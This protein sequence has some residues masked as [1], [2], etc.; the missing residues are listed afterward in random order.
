MAFHSTTHCF[1]SPVWLT[2][3]GAAFLAHVLPAM[4]GT[5]T[6]VQVQSLAPHCL[7]N[8]RPPQNNRPAPQ[9]NARFAPAPAAPRR[10]ASVSVRLAATQRP[11]QNSRSVSVES[12]QERE[13]EH[14]QRDSQAPRRD[15]HYRR[16]ERPEDHRARPERHEDRRS[17]RDRHDGDRNG[18]ERD[19]N[20]NRHERDGNRD[21]RDGRRR[22]ESRGDKEP[23]DRERECAAAPRPAVRENERER[24]RDP[25]G[26]QSP[27]PSNAVVGA[28]SGAPR[29]HHS[30]RVRLDVCRR[31]V[32]VDI[33]LGHCASGSRSYLSNKDSY[34]F[35]FVYFR[36][37]Y[38]CF[39]IMSI[40][41]ICCPFFML[42]Y[43]DSWIDLDAASGHHNVAVHSLHPA[44]NS[45]EFGK[46]YASVELRRV[47]ADETAGGKVDEGT[48]QHPPRPPPNPQTSET[49]R[50]SKH[51]LPSESGNLRT[52]YGNFG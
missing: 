15:D 18:H 37:V 44:S 46:Y 38:V 28:A 27:R 25:Q 52:I 21:K 16:A 50:L 3:P 48:E 9:Q 24:R 29:Y 30:E 39:G 26:G 11:A 33:D 43:N 10:S 45:E 31:C 13:R 41:I 40:S 17:D 19:D 4:L 32:G 22:K 20:R 49:K 51:R 36:F 7:Q 2:P 12:S 23:K 8:N 6:V 34:L 35:R 1:P 42:H 47:T 5:T 14:G